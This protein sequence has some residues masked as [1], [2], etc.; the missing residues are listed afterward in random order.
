MEDRAV[1]P[2]IG[3]VLMVAVT[4]IL[5]STVVMFLFP[6]VNDEISETPTANIAVQNI[7]TSNDEVTIMHRGGETFTDSNTEKIVVK[8]NG[9]EIDSFT[10]TFSAGDTKTAAGTISNGDSVQVVWVGESKSILLAEAE[11]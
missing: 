8:V 5:A 3:V 9:A 2:V 7:D 4:V 11:A 1:S 10:G 6:L